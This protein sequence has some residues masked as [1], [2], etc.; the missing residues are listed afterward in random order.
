MHGL[1]DTE[2]ALQEI[3]TVLQQIRPDEVHIYLPTR[4]PAETWAEP[5]S[6]E[7]LMRTR[8]I[9]GDTSTVFHST[10]GSFDLSGCNTVVEAIIDII[11]RHPMRQEELERALG[12][13]TP[14]QVQEAL[15]ELEASGQA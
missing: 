13:W 11:T 5:S 9:L 8:D 12:H 1:N 7:D 6:E 3:A 15:S 4:P 14:G 10:L 2:E